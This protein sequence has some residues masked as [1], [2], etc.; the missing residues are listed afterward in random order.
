MVEDVE[1]KH[2]IIDDVVECHSMMNRKMIVVHYQLMLPSIS[3]VHTKH[4]HLHKLLSVV[5]VDDDDDCKQAKN[6]FH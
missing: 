5:V 1:N 6:H 2:R 3:I 4:D